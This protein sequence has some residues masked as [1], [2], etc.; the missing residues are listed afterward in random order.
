MIGDMADLIMKKVRV[1]ACDT[2][3]AAFK[4]E[5]TSILKIC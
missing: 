4:N 2:A 1:G 5:G 3:T